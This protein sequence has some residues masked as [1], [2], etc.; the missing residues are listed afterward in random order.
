MYCLN[1]H[2][3]GTAIIWILTIFNFIAIIIIAYNWKWIELMRKEIWSDWELLSKIDGKKP[4][5]WISYNIGQHAI[6]SAK[7]RAH[8]DKFHRK[9]RKKKNGLR[10]EIRDEDYEKWKL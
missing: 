5:S 2:V 9:F 3:L 7:Y 4:E 10:E 6:I 1:T 8:L